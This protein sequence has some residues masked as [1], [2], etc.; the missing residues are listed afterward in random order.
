MIVYHEASPESL[1]H[2]LRDGLKRAD[3]GPKTDKLVQR[4]DELLD[5][6]IPGEVARHKVCRQH[7]LYAYAQE[8]GK[9]VDIKDGSRIPIE[10]FAAQSSMTI[11]VLEVDPTSCYVS[12]LDAY[13][14]F[15]DAVRDEAADSQLQRL[16][17]AYWDRISRLD[18]ADFG[19]YRRPEIMVAYDVPA[20]KISLVN[21]NL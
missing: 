6:C 10:D 12:D 15:V 16:S 3:S 8:A 11:L 20:T 17:D 7:S 2:I 13:D 9:I 4:A 19:Q 18:T 14:A 5:D 21:D 1:P